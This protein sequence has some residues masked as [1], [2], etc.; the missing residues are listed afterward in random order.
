MLN[1]THMIRTKETHVGRQLEQKNTKF[2]YSLDKFQHK[3]CFQNLEIMGIKI[4]LK[5]TDTDMV[6]ETMFMWQAK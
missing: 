5:N 4:T 1:I 6:N 3:N 2:T